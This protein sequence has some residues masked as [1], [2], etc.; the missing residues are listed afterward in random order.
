MNWCSAKMIGISERGI[1]DFSF[2]TREMTYPL[3]ANVLLAAKLALAEKHMALP[4][5]SRTDQGRT[6]QI[7][8]YIIPIDYEYEADLVAT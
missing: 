1:S 5:G 3:A 2:G 7:L 4:P 6:T 8:T